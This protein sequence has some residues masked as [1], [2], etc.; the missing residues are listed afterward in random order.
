MGLRKRLADVARFM[1]RP[2]YAPRAM[3]WGP[4]FGVTLATMIVL[5]L[6]GVLLPAGLLELA[7]GS[8]GVLPEGLQEPGLGPRQVFEYIL[9]APL[10]EEPLH[11]G[12]LSGRR[13]ALRFAAFG[14]AALALFVAGYVVGSGGGRLI[15]LFGVATAFAGLIQWGFTRHRD[16]EL[17]AWF[18][19][20]FRWMVWGSAV[21]FGLVHLGRFT[22]LT[23]PLG[24]VVVAPL[25][26]GGMLLAYTRTRL[27]LRAAIVQHS[28][29][30]LALVCVILSGV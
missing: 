5:N 4:G 9:L 16:A 14:F 17:P 24:V 10:I 22:A 7:L 25:M 23:S 13:A 26:V 2:T 6:V 27:G 21:V 12:W 30:N 29:Y 18:I 20:R 11:R 19:A 8:S 3:A 15:A 1:L 28:A